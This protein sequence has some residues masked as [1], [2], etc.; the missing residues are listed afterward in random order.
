[1]SKL[2]V[3]KLVKNKDQYKSQGKVGENSIHTPFE[4]EYLIQNW[5]KLLEVYREALQ[6]NLLRYV[7]LSFKKILIC[8]KL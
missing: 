4:T 3:Q 6:I 7:L 5:T 8:C 1:M 2:S